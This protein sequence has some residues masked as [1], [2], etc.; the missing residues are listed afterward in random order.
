MNKSV[1][2]LA[3]LLWVCGG[4]PQVNGDN[5][6]FDGTWTLSND[7]VSVSGGTLHIESNGT[8]DDGWA[9]KSLSIS[10]STQNPVVIQQRERLE[11]GGMDYRL[12]D[13]GIV[14]GD[15][16]TLWMTYLPDFDGTNWTTPYYGWHFSTAWDDSSWSKIDF[17]DVPGAGFWTDA[18]ANYWAVT[19]MVLTPAGGELFLK[20]DDAAQGWYSD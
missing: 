14:F 2:F 1:V 20:P 17:P 19:K 16:S 15:G 8:T 5:V 3:G 12:P 11:S 18:T 13:E 7:S 9:K 4:V 6:P 10:L